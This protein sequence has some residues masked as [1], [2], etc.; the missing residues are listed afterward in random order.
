MSYRLSN[1]SIGKLD[2]VHDDLQVVVR[3]AI[4]HTTQDFSV[5]EGIRSIAR[6]RKLFDRGA[7]KTMRSRHITGHA[8]DLAPWLDGGIRWD[9]PLFYPIAAAMRS[10]ALDCGVLIRWGGVWDTPLNKLPE[11]AKGIHSAVDSYVDRRRNAGKRAFIDGPHFELHKE[12]Y[13]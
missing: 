2:T 5:I 7:S 1:R 13:P 3:L 9:W 8:V 11:D 6:Q 4:Q 12:N 10:A